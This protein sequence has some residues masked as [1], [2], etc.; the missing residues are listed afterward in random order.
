MSK[1]LYFSFLLRQHSTVIFGLPKNGTFFS[2]L[3][4]FMGVQQICFYQN[5]YICIHFQNLDTGWKLNFII[6]ISV[7]NKIY[8]EHA[9]KGQGSF[10]KFYPKKHENT[11]YSLTWGGDFQ[12]FAR[13]ATYS[14]LSPLA[15]MLLYQKIKIFRQRIRKKICLK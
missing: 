14:C 15:S 1:I 7:D 3:D 11:W 10:V 6:K 13:Y 9:Q 2:L 12:R 5:P 4:T 8:T